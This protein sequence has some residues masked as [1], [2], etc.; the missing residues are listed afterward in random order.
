[1]ICDDND[2]DAAIL[3]SSLSE[4]AASVEVVR[5]RDGDEALKLLRQPQPF[6]LVVIDQFL[7]RRS[8][9]EVIATLR[10][11]GHF[12]ACPIVMLTSQA[13]WDSETEEIRALGVYRISE[14]P[15]TLDGYLEIAQS[16]AALCS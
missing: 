7:P 2:A 13:G 11:S 10:A 3:I 9:R 14:K 1:M 6:D 12:P 5:A 4:T 8:G 16:L 15:F